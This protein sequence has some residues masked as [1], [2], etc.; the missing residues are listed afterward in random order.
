MD[1][2]I[3]DQAGIREVTEEGKAVDNNLLPSI[4]NIGYGLTSKPPVYNSSLNPNP[5]HLQVAYI[6]A[7][8]I[9]INKLA[10][11]RERK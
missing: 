8:S 6:Y 11:S 1:E 2:T 10:S 4:D 5:T 7:I 3:S 9:K